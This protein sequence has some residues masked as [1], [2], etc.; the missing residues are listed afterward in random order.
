VAV[1]L[2]V[3]DIVVPGVPASTRRVRTGRS[4]HDPFARTT[5]RRERVLT[6]LCTTLAITLALAVIVLRLPVGARPELG[7]TDAIGKGATTLNSSPFADAIRAQTRADLSSVVTIAKRLDLVFK[8]Y[9]PD[10][11]VLLN[12]YLPQYGFV[13]RT[14]PSTRAGEMSAATSAHVL[15]L[16]EYAGPGQCVFARVVDRQAATTVGPIDA[17]C[18]A[19]AAPKLGWTALGP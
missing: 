11:S 19:A 7:A 17:P 10:T 12:H 1:P 3:S 4:R 2:A 8:S 14:E 6:R 9:V 15:V 18:R 13:A 16:A 5:T